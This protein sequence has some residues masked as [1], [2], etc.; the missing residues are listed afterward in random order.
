MGVLT[1]ACL[2][3]GTSA[4]AA[5]IGPPN[6]RDLVVFTAQFKPSL[7]RIG[8]GEA[9]PW[10]TVQFYSPQAMVASQTEQCFYVLDRP[11]F[12]YE[13]YKIWRIDPDGAGKVV[14]A[15]KN[16]L[17]H[18]PFGDPTGLGFDPEGR[19]LL[20][21]A[22]TGTWRL[23]PGGQLRQVVANKKPL[24]KITAATTGAAGVTLLASSYQYEITGGA[25]I[26]LAPERDSS[27]STLLPES[28]GWTGMG[29]DNVGIYSGA[30]NSTG[31]QVPIR[32]WQN[33]GGLYAVDFAKSP[34]QVRALVANG[35]PAG[36]EWDTL[37]R[38]IR[39]VLVDP[40]G[41][42]VLVDQGSKKT[43]GA[44]T[45][46]STSVINGGIHVLHPDG[47]LEELLCKNPGRTSTP[48]RQPTGV[49]VWDD[50]TYLV[51][52]P[53]LYVEGGVMEG[54]GGLGLLRLDGA[55][56]P[57]WKLGWRLKP[58]TVAILRAK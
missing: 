57:R 8:G 38:T 26:E 21:D 31:R 22:S 24:Y 32:V 48:F 52:D 41:R 49:A 51:A 10:G 36:P 3:L 9:Q 47:R 30:G 17:N 1:C 55:R 11:K 50:Q 2:W 35:L 20:S 54:P 23:D 7:Y 14:Y 53:E 33:Q 42:I 39:Q 29:S 18:G 15:A 44:G 25:M 37:W 56:D 28:T 4:V 16:N 40:A 19:L 27:W 12:N 46:R 6:D 13:N 43:F 58:N 5:L 45:R 34:L